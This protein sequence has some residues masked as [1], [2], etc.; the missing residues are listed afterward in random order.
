MM[1]A[2]LS[3]LGVLGLVLSVDALHLGFWKA[4]LDEPA[5]LQELRA[6]KR[7]AT[8]VRRYN[9]AMLYSGFGLLPEKGNDG[10]ILLFVAFGSLALLAKAVLG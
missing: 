2:V 9:R 5:F 6:R 1:T 3:L 7:T 10:A 4:R 8:D